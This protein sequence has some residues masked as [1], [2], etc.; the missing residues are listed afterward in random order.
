[1]LLFL[2]S[3]ENSL[4]GHIDISQINMG[5]FYLDEAMFVENKTYTR[6]HCYRF[7]KR[8]LAIVLSLLSI[9]LLAIP[10][11]IIA[12][13]IRLDSKG[14]AIYRQIRRGRYCKPFVCYKFRSM[15]IDAPQVASRDLQEAEK[16]ITRIGRF[17]RKTSLDELPQLFN[18]LKG[19][20]S[21]IGYRPLILE[22]SRL[23]F[24][25]NEQ[26]VFSARPGFSGIAQVSGRDYVGIEEKVRYDADYVTHASL[27]LDIKL[28]VRTVVYI[29]NGTGIHE[30]TLEEE[31]KLSKNPSKEQ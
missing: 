28:V 20:M 10:M 12:I 30:G 8:L 18:I 5:D 25:R 1:M 17:I 9:V 4:M 7:F 11:L 24:M 31:D 6:K 19:E 29:F 2:P 14:P 26:G 21:F 16:Y 22:E 15:S 27:W 23:N 3:K 13:A